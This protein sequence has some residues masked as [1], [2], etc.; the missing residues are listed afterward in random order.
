MDNRPIVFD[1][2]EAV[3]KQKVAPELQRGYREAIV[4]F[5]Y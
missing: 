1:E 4:K 3:L 2:W 5:R